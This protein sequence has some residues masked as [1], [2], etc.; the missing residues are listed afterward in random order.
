MQDDGAPS[1][2]PV[3]DL[4]TVSEDK[5]IERAQVQRELARRIIAGRPYH[6]PEDLLRRPDLRRPS[7]APSIV[8]LLL[9]ARAAGMDAPTSLH[10][11]II[12]SAHRTGVVVG[13]ERTDKTRVAIAHPLGQEL[14]SACLDD[15]G[16][17]DLPSFRLCG[18]PPGALAHLPL[19]GR[20]QARALLRGP[21]AQWA[22]SL[23]QDEEPL[24]LPPTEESAVREL[25][26]HLR[27]IQAFGRGALFDQSVG[28][29]AHGDPPYNYL[30]NGCSGVPNFDFK[31][32]CDEHD[33]CYA[34]TPLGFRWGCDLELARC[35]AAHGGPEHWVLGVIYGIG[36]LVL[37][38]PLSLP[39]PGIISGG[40]APAH[41]A[42]AGQSTPCK[43]AGHC[44]YRFHMTGV[45]NK[46]P[47]QLSSNSKYQFSFSS[48]P[49]ASKK[50]TTPPF[51]APVGQ[52]ASGGG[53]VSD[54]VDG[55]VCGTS[56]GPV[57]L[58][59]EEPNLGFGK[60]FNIGPFRCCDDPAPG[61]IVLDFGI[62]S[63]MLI[64]DRTVFQ[65]KVHIETVCG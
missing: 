39:F 28:L 62:V 35:I 52:D 20:E 48:G 51:Y 5:L 7:W 53:I 33:L 23:F 2:L 21:A 36:V 64:K 10:Q 4:N 59:V 6:S 41:V 44:K 29:G 50:Y 31:E 3:I 22:G 14:A 38:G 43:G 47:D 8:K 1:P 63:G 40:D 25:S 27:A 42:V 13:V 37:G 26:G 17:L 58:Y 15:D 49:S 34:H 16:E 11:P 65:L 61:D 12:R 24:H 54:W 32:C 60:Q 9:D 18:W 57:T 19:D 30:T 45:H 46:G 56:V 55:G